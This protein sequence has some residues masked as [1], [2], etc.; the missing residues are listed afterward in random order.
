LVGLKL[1]YGFY[2]VVLLF[3]LFASDRWIESLLNSLTIFGGVYLLWQFRSQLTPVTVIYGFCGLGLLLASGG[4]MSLSRLA[5]GIVP[6]SI[7]LGMFLSRHPRCGYLILGAFATL[8]AR[9]AV[10]FAQEMW[11]G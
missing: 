10:R 11:V 8:L 3:L 9:L 2:A 5:Y 1:V 4:T 7:A 6:L